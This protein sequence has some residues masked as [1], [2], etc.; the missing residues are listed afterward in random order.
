MNVE[1]IE[2]PDYE[3]L[4]IE[5]PWPE[6]LLSARVAW[7]KA[8]TWA[9]E[10]WAEEARWYEHAYSPESYATTPF[11]HVKP[12]EKT[13]EEKRAGF[14]QL[15]Y[16][17]REEELRDCLSASHRVADALLAQ[18]RAFQGPKDAEDKL[19]LAYAS[20]ANVAR[21]HHDALRDYLICV[22][23]EGPAWED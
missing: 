2:L 18:A 6:D 21:H 14:Y 22:S 17:S 10:A 5:L 23:E 16:R 12:W 7:E 9:H 20:A 19:A 15:L 11:P 13:A 4:V 1:I 3:T 8:S